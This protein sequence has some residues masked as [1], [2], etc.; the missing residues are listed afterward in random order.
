[1]RKQKPVSV[2][3]C[4]ELAIALRY[5]LP[6]VEDS[7]LISF[8]ASNLRPSNITRGDAALIVRAALRKVGQT[9]PTGA[10]PFDISWV[11]DKVQ[12]FAAVSLLQSDNSR[13]RGLRLTDGRIIPLE[14]LGMGAGPDAWMRDLVIP[15]VECGDYYR[16][17][18][19]E[20][21]LCQDCMEKACQ[22]NERLDKGGQ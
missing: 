17:G 16:A 19:M 21:D 14:L 6:F 15:C 1:M 4:E 2:Y 8:G 20:A 18:E 13:M 12:Q 9:P 10:V 3:L 7:A 11:R 22:E 5:A